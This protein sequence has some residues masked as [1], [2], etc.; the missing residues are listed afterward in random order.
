M[1][2]FE[3]LKIKIKDWWDVKKKL[4]MLK[5]MRKNLYELKLREATGEFKKALLE[6]VKPFPI[7]LLFF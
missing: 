4:R 1:S 6:Q 5:I 7:I 3:Y 2:K